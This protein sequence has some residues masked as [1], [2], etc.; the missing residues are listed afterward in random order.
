MTTYQT[1]YSSIVNPGS[2]RVKGGERASEDSILVG[3]PQLCFP[4]EINIENVLLLIEGSSCWWMS[5]NLLYS[6]KRWTRP[7]SGPRYLLLHHRPRAR[8]SFHGVSHRL[9]R[10]KAPMSLRRHRTWQRRESWRPSW[11]FCCRL[12]CQ[13]DR[14]LDLP[15]RVLRTLVLV[16]KAD[17]KKGRRS[18]RK[19]YGWGSPYSSITTETQRLSLKKMKPYMPTFSSR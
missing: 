14:V 6:R 1:L 19:R 4:E 9:S 3:A 15:L 13:S 12:L 5:R 8:R 17:W 16:C 18:A 2:G 11:R 7:L 10:L